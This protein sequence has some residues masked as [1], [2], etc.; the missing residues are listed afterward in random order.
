MGAGDHLV[1][2]ARLEEGGGRL[3]ADFQNLGF[4]NS[5]S[6]RLLLALVVLGYYINLMGRRFLYRN[7]RERRQED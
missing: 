7:N 6:I 5:S 3:G 2:G 4:I 1:A